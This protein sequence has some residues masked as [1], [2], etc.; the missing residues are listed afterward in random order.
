MESQNAQILHY[1]KQGKTISPLDA[2]QS[3]GCFRLASRIYELR[4]AGWPIHCER[5]EVGDKKRVAFY[6]LEM[7]RSAW[8][9]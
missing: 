2:L 3:F 1:L 5:K 4:D 8:P 7:D 6:S 9:A